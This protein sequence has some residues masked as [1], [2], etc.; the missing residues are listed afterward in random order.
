MVSPE[1]PLTA[2]VAVNHMWLRHF[3]KALVPTVANFGISGAAPSHPQLLDWLAVE[4]VE[5]NWSMKSLHRL[6]VTSSTYR[7]QSSTTNA[8]DPNLSVD[9]DNRFLWRMNPRRMEAE[10]VR[11]SILYVAGQLDTSIGGP[12]EKDID[13]H[14]RGMYFKHTPYTQMEF[15]K[16]FD[17]ANPDECYQ[18]SESI[19]PQQAL[20]LSNSKL[21]L[22]MARRL[23]QKLSVQV[24]GKADAQ[25]AFV[26]AAFETVIGRP[27]SVAESAR[28]VEFLAKQADLLN[29]SGK[30]TSIGVSTQGEIQ[31]ASDPQMRAR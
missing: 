29:A 27:P 20:A 3:G 10:S 31:P 18:R 14:R 28:T 24:E 26:T 23:A 12:D 8:K 30:L 13:S 22:T 4:F 7:M 16:L 11:D 15:L 21:S 2:R 17:A 1:N 6:M 5:K 25:A 9:A 19:V